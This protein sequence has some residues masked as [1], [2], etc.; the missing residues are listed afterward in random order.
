[1]SHLF[2]I[3]DD[4]ESRVFLRYVWIWRLKVEKVSALCPFLSRATAESEV[5]VDNLDNITVRYIREI[6]LAQS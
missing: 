6:T 5:S 4:V 3:D 1:M 2:N